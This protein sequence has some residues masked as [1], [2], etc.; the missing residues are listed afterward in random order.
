MSKFAKNIITEM[1]SRELIS[2]LAGGDELR[3]HLADT[4]RTV[5]CGFDPTAE[6]LHIGSLVPLLALKR[7]QMAGHRPIA[8]VGGATGLIG[9]PSFKAVERQLNSAD[10]VAQWVERLK[11]Q[12]SQFLDFEAKSN[13][14]ILANNLDWTEQM[15]MLSFLRDI[16]KHFS[17]NAMIQKESV[18]QRIDRDGEGISYTEFSYMILQSFD[19]AELNKRYGCTVQIGGSDQWGN[20]TGGIDLTRRLHQQQVFGATLPLV[21]K[22][23][24][25]KF[26]KTETGT[27]WI[28][29]KFTSPYAFYQFWLNTADTDVYKYLKYFSFIELDAIA[30]IQRSD[31]SSNTKPEAQAILA[32]AVTELVHGK[33]GLLAARRISEALFSGDIS[34]LTLDDLQQLE[35][36]GLPC[37]AM[38]ASAQGIVEILVLT[39]LAKS[40]K[41]AREF[42][43]NNAVSVNGESVSS[44]E[45]QLS[46]A[47]ALH[48]RYFVLRR[49]K[50][51]FHLLK[52]V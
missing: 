12:L 26:G 30:E 33:T 24:G 51:Q 37:T 41:M 38:T 9:D 31:Q 35:L 13:P 1:E 21:T 39:E 18:K 34:K 27:I 7:F 45:F 36:D 14:A 15:N 52:L 16:G 29:P 4:S 42:I 46:R 25:S 17:I 8:L 22:S 50:K 47:N 23:D 6:S 2:Q 20:I 40:N 44:V 48:G 43:T 11:P 32:A 19:F 49:G 3:S 28:S 5:Y 10:I